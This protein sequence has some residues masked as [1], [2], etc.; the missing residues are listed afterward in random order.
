MSHTHKG[1][2]YVLAVID[3]KDFSSSSLFKIADTTLNSLPSCETFDSYIIPCSTPNLCSTRCTI[4]GGRYPCIGCSFDPCLG[5]V[6]F[7][8]YLRLDEEEESLT[9]GEARFGT[10]DE[11]FSFGLLR[12]CGGFIIVKKHAAGLR[13]LTISL[14]WCRRRALPCTP[15]KVTLMCTVSPFFFFSSSTFNYLF[16]VCC[17]HINMTAQNYI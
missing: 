11:F 8:L 17:L 7:L 15:E 14:R 5:A 2:V 3:S 13:R 6:R 9:Y 16:L 1:L 10:R 4:G 12:L